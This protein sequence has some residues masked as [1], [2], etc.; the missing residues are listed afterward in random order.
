MVIFK[1]G[2][3]IN[4]DAMLFAGL[5]GDL[6]GLSLNH[7]SSVGFQGFEDRQT[8]EITAVS[9]VCSLRRQR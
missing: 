6:A 5:L 7:T 3:K 9:P 4:E 2:R 1:S 8:M